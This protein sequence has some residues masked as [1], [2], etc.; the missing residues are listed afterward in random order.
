MAV[1]YLS[2]IFCCKIGITD[3][4]YMEE[5][6]SSVQLLDKSENCFII[7]IRLRLFLMTFVML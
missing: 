6:M 1:N 5:A 7:T 2:T 4:E 3:K